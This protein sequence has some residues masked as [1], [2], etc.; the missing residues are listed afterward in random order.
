MTAT[1][2]DLH[3][4]VLA[5]YR[6]FVQSFLQIA[7]DRARAFVD[8]AFDDQALWPQP[9]VQLSP[10][11]AL[12]DTVDDLARAGAIHQLAAALFRTAQGDPFRLYRHQRQALDAARRGESF[13]VTSGTG[14]GK[15]LCYFLPIMSA[16]AQQSARPPGV[17]AL[18]VYP[19]NALVNSQMQAL[20]T[21]AQQYARRTGRAFPI[22]FAKYTGETPNAERDAIRRDP[23]QILLTNYVMVELMLV[24]PE[25]RNLV[26]PGA[27]RF[28][29]F[30][31]LHT[32]RGRQ[33]ADVA[34]LV[35]RLKERCAAPDIIH[36]GT[37]AT[38]VAGRQATADERR[39]AVA[40]FAT[41]LFGHPFDATRVIE[42]TLAPVT[43]GGPPTPDE[44]CAAL[45]APLPDDWEAFRHH[46]LMRWMEYA[47]GIVQEPDGRLA[48]QRP[49]T[50]A[51]RRLAQ[52]AGADEATCAQALRAALTHGSRLAHAA[53]NRAF[54]FKLHQFISQGRALYATLEPVDRRA[55]SL[56]GQVQADGD[57]LWAPL[58]FCRRCGQDYYRVL[59]I[60]DDEG[61]RFIPLPV[62]DDVADND[63]SAPAV[64]YL[65]LTSTDADWSPDQIPEEWLDARGRLLPTWRGRTP[66]EVWVSPDGRVS[67]TPRDG[68]LKMWFQ[69][70]PF[71]LCLTCG[72]FYTRREREFS[73]LAT[74]SSEGRSSATTALAVS[75]LRHA[76]RTGAVR[77]KLLTFTDNRQDA[78][79]QAGHF[80][81]F[82]HLAVLRSALVAALNET[83]PLTPDTVAASVVRHCGLTLRDIAQNPHLDPET[84]AA[85]EV[86]NVF[87]DLVEYWLYDDLRYGWQIAQPN[88]EQLGLLRIAYRGLDDL[89]REDRFWENIP[90][91]AQASA[92]ERAEI[93]RAILDHLRRKLAINAR[94]L[95]E[96]GQQQLRRR[97]QTNLNEFWGI[98]PDAPGL[99][100][101]GCAVVPGQSPRPA[102][103]RDERT[104]GLGERSA[105]GRFLRTRLGVAGDAYRATL[106]N[107]LNLLVRH[108]MIARLDP[109]DDHQRFQLN[110]ACLIW[111]RGDG[112]P[113]PP[114]PMVVRRGGH[115]AY[116]RPDRRPNLFFQRFYRE[117]AGTLAALEAREHT[118]QVVAPGERERRE[119]RF[120]WSAADT[121]KDIDLGRRLPYLVCSPTMEL[122]VD[123]ADLE[124]VHLRN[125][126]PTPANYAQRSGR[127]GRQGQPGMIVTYCRATDNHDQYFFRQRDEMVAGSVQAPKIDI[128]SEA[129]VRAH[130]HAMWLA[131]IRLPLG[132]SIQEVI[133]ID[134]PQLP[135]HLNV[136]ESI[137]LSDERRAEL[138]EQ[139]R[140][141]LSAD[142]ALLENA[143]W[144]SDAW[145]DRVIEEAPQAF[146]R[147]FDRWRDLYRS[148]I[149]QRDTARIEEDRARTRDDQQRARR[150]QDEARRQLNLLLQVDVAREEGD[151]YPYRY[152][153][154]EGFLP[155]Y[156]FP[157]LP[158]RAWVPRGDEGEFIPRP[159]S[160]AI[161]EFA[162][163]NFIYHEGA[164]WEV[165]AFRAPPG[166]LDSRRS[167][168]RVCKECGAFSD[169]A[170]DLCPSCNVRFDAENSNIF[171]LL[172]MTNVIAR[173]RERITANEEHR[174]RRGYRLRDA[175]AYATAEGRA[176]VREADTVVNGSPIVRLTYAP[177]ATV[178]RINCGWRASRTDGFLIDMETGEWLRPDDQGVPA[179]RR[180]TRNRQPVDPALVHLMVRDTRNLLLI[181][182]PGI[183]LE[184]DVRLETSLRY[185][186]QRGIERAFQIELSEIAG[187]VVGRGERRALLFYEMSEG[188][189]GVLRR[190]VEEADALAWVARE[191]LTQCHFD[192][193][194]RDLKP[195]CHA[196]CYECLLSFSNWIEALQ[197]NRHHIRDLLIQIAGGRTLP[198]IGGRDYQEHLAWL[199]SQTDERSELERRFLDELAR[200]GAR[201]P[202]E[203]QKAIAEPHCI[204]D[205]FYAPN[206]CVF[207]DGSVHDDPAQRASDEAVRQE[208]RA[209]GYRVVSIRYD[210][211]LRDQIAREPEIFG[212]V[213]Q[214]P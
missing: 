29:V 33:G 83:S 36:I 24:R 163:G 202:D 90:P 143:G 145:L 6:D 111:E 86:W 21:L 132:Q 14:S 45:T 87:T 48:R 76:A 116:I 12:D 27:L 121:T 110:A 120:R 195:E 148:A 140:A 158:V 34:M 62:D 70:A 214:G 66:E 125:V 170:C 213:R 176:R 68:A 61:E 46:P 198:R 172:E 194:G 44:L 78:S 155:G 77:D 71:A 2:F 207:C 57:R 130:I 91:L 64:G 41:R 123:I 98:D 101:A 109:V 39:Q 31:E 97:A 136:I 171:E 84:Q 75:M 55:F 108:G 38:M 144:W 159:R 20:D 200:L 52:D 118:A 168:V 10:A 192:D 18:I 124:L 95:Q 37:S 141:A 142:L 106:L 59:R 169:V 72:E 197:I 153:A 129:L 11:Y 127:A 35:R 146:D 5:D 40:D 206:I 96:S 1:I 186:L 112:S 131:Y 13:V 114:D 160:L 174:Q 4:S 150:R 7:D 79:L 134:D 189:A 80:N 15:S 65:M 113:P 103:E 82:V 190:L 102:W 63:V 199:Q 162:P 179:S 16:L 138:R 173:R 42:E 30:D 211:P 187:E 177:A 182:L 193:D 151:F 69:H 51:A 164:K 201:L 100:T 88:L 152:L 56:D 209:R 47:L 9:L 94:L 22:T 92:A 43:E 180:A 74:L 185:A 175:Y 85:R 104:I 135:L 115:E 181:R 58:V 60:Q 26:H 32:Y 188:G 89:C 54:A 8:Q 208:L 149:Q 81:D 183:D 17:Q 156:N 178:L 133:S 191:A 157:A 67:A 166:G 73:K 28:L 53:G 105:I 25:D 147:A 196:A 122:G 165:I 139:I 49:L 167:R 107:L 119:R 23:P 154:S 117:T 184:R 210:Q 205:F 203:A 99:R 204:P 212:A 19:M 93:A 3:A 50:E 128:T 137:R 126:P 161:D